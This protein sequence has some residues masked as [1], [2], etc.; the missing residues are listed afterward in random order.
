MQC[1]SQMHMYVC[2]H[3]TLSTPP[4]IISQWSDGDA[5]PKSWA[6]H[7]RLNPVVPIDYDTVESAL[8]AVSSGPQMSTLEN[9]VRHQY[10]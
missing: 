4:K 3:S 1:N 5:V 7:Y 8:D 6:R 2:T 10:R 9:G